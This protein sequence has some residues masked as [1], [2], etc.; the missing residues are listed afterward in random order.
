M[1]SKI[2]HNRLFVKHR[3]IVLLVADLIVVGFSYILALIFTHDFS[4]KQVVSN[5]SFSMPVI[6]LAIALLIIYTTLFVVYKVNKS[7]WEYIGEKELWNILVTLVIA[8]IIC[9]LLFFILHFRIVFYLI[10]IIATVL[11]SFFMFG[12]R[13][14]YRAYRESVL[15]AH[16][17]FKGRRSLIVGAGSAGYILMK[18][19]QKNIKLN[20]KLVGFIDDFQDGMV[21]GGYAVL[22]K[23]KDLPKI[24][25]KKEIDLVFIAMPSADKKTIQKVVDLC[26]ILN[27]EIKIMAPGETLFMNN[28][29]NQIRS[30]TIE[31]LLGREEAK[32]SSEEISEYIKGE[33]VLVTGAAGSIGSQL[34]MEIFKFQ[35]QHLLLLDVNE[36]GLYMLE[37]ELSCLK[38]QNASYEN[39]KITSL[40]ASIREVAAL[41]NIFSE[42][43]I[44]IVYHAA[45]HKHVPLME[46][47]P[48]EAIKNNIVGT[49]N[50]IDVAIKHCAKRVIMISTDKAV[51]P[52][53][54]MGASKRM[55]ELI[56][57]SR[58]L[59]KNTKIAAVRFG[60]VLGS[61]GS[62][63]PIF[64]NQIEKG[65]PITLTSKKIIRYFM[66]IPEAAQLVL[67]AGYYA[68]RGEIFI[69]DMGEPVKI[70]DLAENLIRLSG[71]RPYKDIDIIEIGLRPGEK[72]FEE[73]QYSEEKTHST[74]NPMI[75]VNEIIDVDATKVDHKV[76]ELLALCQEPVDKTLLKKKL[77]E[78]IKEVI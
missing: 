48:Q 18:E 30:V 4:V 8:F 68:D 16:L 2:T 38:R 73:L 25:T 50:V 51:N 7:L 47:R 71:L 70:L 67:Q 31:D 39:I 49:R 29:S 64:K 54:V 36:N 42:Y 9:G 14:G 15:N 19:L 10:L 62:V 78:A 12:I 55:T 33:V 76:D 13:L 11:S 59:Q 69:L 23:I 58:G 20:A 34:V 65:G 1:L 46:T 60:N 35:P 26:K 5:Y 43:N 63:I 66:T 56:L 74:A 40:I 44:D 28:T 17:K 75:M 72:M 53:N 45:A 57:Q 6:L 21:V 32:L 52:T 22:G 77:F 27:V 37:Q 24:I 41:E 61:N 3:S